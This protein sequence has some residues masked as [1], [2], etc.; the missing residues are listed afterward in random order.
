VAVE[1]SLPA[2]AKK[3]H[4]RW[5]SLFFAGLGGLVSLGIGLM[6]DQ[7][8]RDLFARTDWLGW[9]GIGLVVLVV[10]GAGAIALKGLVALMRLARITKLNDAAREAAATDDRKAA[11]AALQELIGLYRKRPETAR[12]RAALAGHMQEIVDG[13]DLIRLGERELMTGFDADARRF[14]MESA[15]RVSIVTAVSPRAI[16]GVLFV[17]AENLRLIRRLSELYGG[18][19]GALGLIR[20]ARNVI[21]HLALTG[22]IAIGDSLVQQLIGQG[23]AAKLSARL[24][25]GVVN[26]MLT[27]RVGI[28][29]IDVCRPL[30]FIDGRPPALPDVVTELAKIGGSSDKTGDSPA[31]GS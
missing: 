21:G 15:K 10:V 29:A 24:G 27:A 23:L 4:W 14:V 16:V 12:G 18:R 22:G 31:K 17:L 20:L 5:A 6:V 25:E 3:T 30:P 19:P 11:L 26:G 9:I 8:I 13:R 28:A 2:P 7:L 1:T